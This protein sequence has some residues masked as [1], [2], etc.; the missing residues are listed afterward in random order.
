MVSGVL[1]AAGAGIGFG[2]FQAVN[3]RA[4]QTMDAF[5]ATFLL[6]VIGSASL[7]LFSAATRDLSA[8]W[9]GSPRAYLFFA[10]AGIVHFFLGW[11]FLSLSQQ[12]VGAATTGAVLGSTPLIGS[13]L[14]AIVLAEPLRPLTAVGIL[15]AAVGVTLLSLRRTA[16]TQRKVPWFALGAA[17]SWGSSPLF[18]RWGLADLD[19]PIVGVTFGLLAATAVYAVALALWRRRR[20]AEPISREGLAWVTA[21]GVLVAACIALQWI[22]FDRTAVAVA[23]T[24]MQLS[25]PTVV[26]VA[27]L[28]VKSDTER[29]TP[30]VILGMAAVLCGSVVVVLAGTG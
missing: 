9:S 4:N 14:A 6:L 18:I 26:T 3:R 25:A 2:V 23:I 1:F 27:P 20:P 24:V 28:I 30:S 16:S 8:L 12:Q 11:T 21:A 17:A 7:A 15:L 10:G 19:D 5:R 13:L 29:P 22:A